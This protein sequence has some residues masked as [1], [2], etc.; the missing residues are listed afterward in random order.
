[1]IYTMREIF[2]FTFDYFNHNY[3]PAVASDMV[4]YLCF[5]SLADTIKR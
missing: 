2:F 4:V 1:M 5:V 3:K